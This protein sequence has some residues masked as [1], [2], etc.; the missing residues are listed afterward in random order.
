MKTNIK[1]HGAEV[2]L[3]IEGTQSCICRELGISPETYHEMHYE[4]SYKWFEMRGYL[5]YTARVFLLSPLFHRWWNQQVAQ[6]EQEFI[7]KYGKHDFPAKLM[8]DALEEIIVN[9]DVVPARELLREMH[10][11][12]TMV[13]Q[14]NP[15]L[16]LTKPYRHE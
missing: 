14:I 10:R 1:T 5:E 7:A 11:E 6:K 16:K 8:R 12:G 2:T 4:M 3:Y 15:E 13:L 9:M